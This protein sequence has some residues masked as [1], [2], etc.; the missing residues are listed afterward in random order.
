MTEETATRL[1]ESIAANRLT[2]LS[3]AGLS[4]AAP[5]SVP[6]AAA[7]A[8]QCAESYVTQVGATIPPE[9]AN[10][11]ERM[12]LWFRQKHTL[13]NLFIGQLV[14]WA[15]FNTTCNEG[16][17][18]IADFLACGA[19]CLA[20]TTNYDRLVEQ[21]AGLLGEPDFQAI[22]DVVDL[23]R[24]ADYKPYLKV[25]GCCALGRSRLETIWCRDQLADQHLHQRTERFRD[26]MRVNLLGRDVLIVG[27]WSDW[28]YLS[29]IFADTID[30]VGPGK[31]F[32][33]DPSPP[34]VLQ[35]KA[36]AMWE[37]AHREG[38]TFYHEQESA[39]DFLLELR[40]HF[41][42]V[43]LR[44]V[45]TDANETYSALFGSVLPN[46]DTGLRTADMNDLYALR[47]DLSG[48]QRHRPV[49][50]KSTSP[51]YRL[52][53]AMHARLL[54]LGATYSRNTY[55][56]RG[57]RI[58]IVSGHGQLMSDVKRS[59]ADEPTPP[60]THDRLVCVGAVP[61]AAA[62][63]I[64]RPDETPTIMRSG[65]AEGWVADRDFLRELGAAHV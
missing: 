51:V 9:V 29:E 3:G 15:Q 43:F 11:L 30:A 59:F 53:A 63:H 55:D 36:P 40:R 21:A 35:A 50:A 57:Q 17:N 10:D 16:H 56:L 4:M 42:I 23:P 5:S 46:V 37:W 19:V 60:I 64:L 33:V 6:S 28:A 65:V 1:M 8:R 25:H 2:I 26:W 61:D 12:A 48:T 20:V 52:H 34:D 27:F 38:I 47:R 58:R 24:D 62:A 13:E 14:P 31:V 32:L 54:N 7:V 22:V 18:A 45:I 39:A 49:R 41:S 44:Q